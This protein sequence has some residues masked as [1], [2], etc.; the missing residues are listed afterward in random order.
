MTEDGELD[1]KKI[2][3]DLSGFQHYLCTRRAHNTPRGYC[4]QWYRTHVADGHK[5]VVTQNGEIKASQQ[6]PDR[7][8]WVQQIFNEWRMTCKTT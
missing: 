1:W 8:Y 4:I 2:L 5:D 7:I 3:E 6:T